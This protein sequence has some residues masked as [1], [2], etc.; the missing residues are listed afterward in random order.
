MQLSGLG[1]VSRDK[2]QRATTSNDT[3]PAD[4]DGCNQRRSHQETPM[5]SQHKHLK[6]NKEQGHGN[7]QRLD[8]TR[9]LRRRTPQERH[10]GV[11]SHTTKLILRRKLLS[12]LR[13]L[14][15]NKR[16]E[17]SHEAR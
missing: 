8:V 9:W 11:V 12:W 2:Q 17:H 10:E 15:G 3:I 1:K 7:K 16:G 5:R 14:L 6:S 13:Q 4:P